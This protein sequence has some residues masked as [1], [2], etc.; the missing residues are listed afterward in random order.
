MV[1]HLVVDGS[2]IATE[3]RKTPS[4]EQLEEA[5]QEFL[6]ERPH[7][8]VIVIVDATFPNRIDKSEFA[9]YEKLIDAG[10]MLTPPAGVIGRGDAF[11]LQV[12]IKAN[13]TVLSNDSFQEFHGDHDWLFEDDRLVGGKPVPGVGWVF[14]DRAPVRGAT[15][16]RAV[17]DAKR[18]ETPE[19]AASTKAQATPEPDKGN[20]ADGEKAPAQSKTVRGERASDKPILNDATAF[21]TFVANYLPGSKVRAVVE[22]FSSHG[23]YVKAGNA[24]C[25]V[26]LRLMGDPAPRSAREVLTVGDEVEFTVHATDP[27]HNAIDLALVPDETTPPPPKKATRKTAARKSPS[28]TTAKKAASTSEESEPA[29]AKKTAARKT[30]AAKKTAAKKTTAKKAATKKTAAKKTTAKKSTAKKAAA[31]KATGTQAAAS[32]GTAAKAPAKKAA[33]S[34]TRKRTVRPA[35]AK[36]DEPKADQ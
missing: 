26:P 34:T 14:V 29:A 36:A 12:A 31:K 28:R 8:H 5:V 35:A 33:G 4:L 7:D 19:P 6:A 17:R 23:A 1:T 13:A 2:N 16:R 27:A 25:Y 11:I 22:S 9:R 18:K 3:G 32:D 20:D 15:S 30:T 24:T 10:W 21:V